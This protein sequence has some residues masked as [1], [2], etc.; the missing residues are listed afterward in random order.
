M[1][2][3][4]NGKTSLKKID[5]S[6]ENQTHDPSVYMS[7]CD[8]TTPRQPRCQRSLSLVLWYTSRG[9]FHYAHIKLYNI[10]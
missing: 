10:I 1:M 3:Y 9:R 7:D 4:N 6:S 8:I 2:A 5:V